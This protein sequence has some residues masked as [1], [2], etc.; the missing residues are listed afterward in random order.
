MYLNRLKNRVK[1]FKQKKIKQRKSK[2]DEPKSLKLNSIFVIISLEYELLNNYYYFIHLLLLTELRLDLQTTASFSLI[3]CLKSLIFTVC[4]AGL[5]LATF[6]LLISL[7]VPSSLHSV[8][9]RFIF[10]LFTP[11][12]WILFLFFTD[13]F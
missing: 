10:F 9:T 13:P 4:V 2:F 6:F 5:R 3:F 12:L 7:S 8:R 11:L 1:L